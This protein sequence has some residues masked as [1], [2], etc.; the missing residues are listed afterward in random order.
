[1]K[2]S[3]EETKEERKE[4]IEA[5]L[6]VDPSL[7]HPADFSGDVFA[8]Q[9]DNGYA[10]FNMIEM[11]KEIMASPYNEQ[12]KIYTAMKIG[13]TMVKANQQEAMSDMLTEILGNIGDKGFKRHD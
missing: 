2:K 4:T 5:F 9:L 12:T 11:T 3:S 6:K 10:E 13:E 8:R 1:M 7:Q